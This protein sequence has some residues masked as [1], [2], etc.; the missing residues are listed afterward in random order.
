LTPSFVQRRSGRSTAFVCGVE[1][2]L[3]E[4][5]DSAAVRDG[6]IEPHAE[7]VEPLARLAKRHLMVAA[8]AGPREVLDRE[9]RAA[10]LD[11]IF[12]RRMRLSSEDVS[13]ID[14]KPD[15]VDS[16]AALYLQSRLLTGLPAERCTVVTDSVDEVRAAVAAGLRVV[17]MLQFVPTV[18]RDLRTAALKRAGA[19]V[20]VG[21]WAELEALHSPRRA[22]SSWRIGA[23]PAS[24]A[25]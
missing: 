10:G 17:G 19:V 18:Q 9:L 2:V 25:G 20:V 13:V 16:H 21:S 15:S 22:R 5:C 7:V 23:H 4:P 6:V 3:V 8:T 24:T 14:G 1:G 12:H 11:R